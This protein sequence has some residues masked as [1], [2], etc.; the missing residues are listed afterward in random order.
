[1]TAEGGICAATEGIN[2][3]LSAFAGRKALDAYMNNRKKHITA[4]SCGNRTSGVWQS[5]EPPGVL[6][7]LRESDY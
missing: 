5:P 4:V 7:L 2:Q 6:H 3:A 1:M